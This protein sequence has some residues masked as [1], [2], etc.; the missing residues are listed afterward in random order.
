MP[1]TAVDIIVILIILLSSILAFVR[2]FV[3][4]FLSLTTWSL[5]AFL[6]FKEYAVVA[7]YFKEYIHQDQIRDFA[8]GAAVFLGVLII[9][10]PLSMYIRSFIKGEHITSID[11]SFGFLFGAA[12]GYLLISIIYLIVSWLLPEEKQPIWLKE[13]NTKPALTYGAEWVK[14]L[15]PQEQRDLMEK[16]AKAAEESSEETVP[17]SDSAKPSAPKEGEGAG[18]P[19]ILKK[20]LEDVKGP[21]K[22]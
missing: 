13:A 5:A 18:K 16:K 8:G 12:R 21:P 17:L 19:D 2:G 6:G 4:E 20:I 9:L 1:H 11:R 10:I 3:R 15:I 14:E 22:P 7:P